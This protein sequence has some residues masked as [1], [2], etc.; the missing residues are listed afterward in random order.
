MG[1]IT[2]VG[3]WKCLIISFPS[4]LDCTWQLRIY[5]TVPCTQEVV[6]FLFMHTSANIT[7]HYLIQHNINRTRCGT[8]EIKCNHC[9]SMLCQTGRS[10]V[11]SM[12]MYTGFSFVSK[13]IFILE[14]SPQPLVLLNWNCGTTGHYRGSNLWKWWHQ[15]NNMATIVDIFKTSFAVIHFLNHLLDQA[16]I[17]YGTWSHRAS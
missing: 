12:F 7:T 13:Y 8:C 2:H 17:L 10:V 11:I 15:Y 9:S 6:K 3:I 14:S 1:N 4:F 5:W 16:K